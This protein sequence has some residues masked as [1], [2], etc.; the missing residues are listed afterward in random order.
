LYL[1]GYKLGSAVLG[2]TGEQNAA[3]PPA[4]VWGEPMQSIR[5][6]VSWGLGL[7]PPLALGVFLLGTLLAV[8]G[9]VL[10][11]LSWSVYLRRAAV[12]RRKRG[13]ITG[14]GLGL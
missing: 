10:V 9:Y 11:R 13:G 8:T 12:R 1:A 6:L 3:P 14:A 2:I 5:E 7:G 4:W